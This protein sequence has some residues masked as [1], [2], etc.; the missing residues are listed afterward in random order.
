MPT[1]RVNR[2]CIANRVGGNCPDGTPKLEM[3]LVDLGIIRMQN[4]L[5]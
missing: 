2:Y 5:D 1:S 4:A 3:S